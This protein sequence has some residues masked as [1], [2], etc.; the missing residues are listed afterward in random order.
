[1]S[2]I[3][4]I[5]GDAGG[6]GELA[7][8][9][10]A[11]C[12][13][14][15]LADAGWYGD[16][17][18]TLVA[19]S[20]PYSGGGAGPRHATG[21][22]HAPDPGREAGDG[23]VAVGTAAHPDLAERYRRHGDDLVRHLVGGFAVAVWDSRRRRL[24]L[25]GDHTGQQTIYW[26][27]RGGRLVFAS[28][29]RAL[30]AD[31]RTGRDLDLV[32]LHHYLTYRYVPAPWSIVAGVRKLAPGSRLIWQDGRVVVDRYWSPAVPAHADAVPAAATGDL[33]TA[34]T[35]AMAV[36]GDPSAGA[37]GDV[38][39]QFRQRLVAAVR[40]Q[41]PADGPPQVLLSGGI[42]AS[43]VA[44]AA[45][46][47]TGRPIRTCTVTFDDP[48]LDQRATARQVAGHLGAEH[49]EYP[50]SGID[51]A[52]AQQLVRWCDEP[53]GDPAAFGSFL[54]ARYAAVR[55]TDVL[56]GVGGPAV[57]G[58]FPH[59]QLLGWLSRWPD[60]PGGLPRVQR[61]G[62]ALVDRSV[63][64]TPVRRL[65]RLLEVAGCAPPLRYARIVGQC[66]GE[67]KDDLYTEALRTELA[68][69][70]SGRL[71]EAAYLAGDGGS[72]LS[73]MIDADR[74]GY[75]PGGVLY[76]WS[77][78][79]SGAGLR[80]RA[81]LLDHR[82]LDW[83]AGLPARCKVPG[84]R[85][86]LARQAAVGWLPAR[87]TWPVPVSDRMPLAG[88]LR[89]ELRDLARDVLTDQTCRDR[90][91]WRPAAVRRLLDEHDAG[92]DHAYTLFTL[93]QLE[94][95]IRHWAGVVAP[96]PTGHRAGLTPAPPLR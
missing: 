87:L 57:Y 39:G 29:L 96:V 84:G 71:A 78:V 34:A 70:D 60:R 23:I 49:Q 61:I 65:G 44:A 63:P 88:W 85:R 22:G 14:A 46:T 3:V 58:G 40:A 64:G 2:A 36:T 10:A 54:V 77:A 37:T 24:L 62:A 20:S 74:R 75:L 9:L 95:W 31:P 15:D 73:R 48:R 43:L 52:V 8:R 33:S 35:G 7:R 19:R 32:A 72:P 30:L 45:A 47:C 90:G 12:T 38:V 27:L 5:V 82:L 94:L 21:A 83:A 11:A 92:L 4:G 79:T 42:G 50:A 18:A 89:V 17:W 93:L 56:S 67:Q 53:F 41:L 1:M 69:V 59:H 68:D 91:L 28:Q 76:R 55:S 16:D 66:S 81:P 51:P 6:D 86:Q 26:Q 25:A 13:P 80:L